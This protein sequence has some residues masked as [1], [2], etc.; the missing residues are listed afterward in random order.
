M[1][2]VRDTIPCEHTPFVTWVL[3][4]INVAVFL[5]LKLL[6][7]PVAVQ[8]LHLYGLVPKRFFHPEWASALGYPPGDYW[9]FLTSMFLHASWTHLLFN[10]WLIWIFADNIEDVMGKPRFLLF[11]LICGLLGNLLHMAFNPESQSPAIGASGAIAGVLG[12]YF[13][14]YPYAKVVIW[15]PILFLPIFMQVPA[16]AFLGVWVIFQL[17]AVT[18]AIVAGQVMDVAWWGH[19]G[20]F[21]AGALLHRLFLISGTLAG[22]R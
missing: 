13:F 1:I 2:P 4:G 5:F 11:Y 20:G 8:I 18:T 9:P 21:L 16:I 14:L 12:A 17:S 7:E 10:I 6:Q 19:I 3:I 22:K 15:I